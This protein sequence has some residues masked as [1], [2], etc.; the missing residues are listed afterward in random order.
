MQKGSLWLRKQWFKN[1]NRVAYVAINL[2]RL[3]AIAEKY[4]LS[5]INVEALVAN[6]IVKKTDKVKILGN[7]E[8]TTKLEVTSH[9]YSASAKAAIEQ[10]GGTINLV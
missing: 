3:Q 1:P 4:K 7:G 2:D 6:G 9:A 5:T 8:L 10:C